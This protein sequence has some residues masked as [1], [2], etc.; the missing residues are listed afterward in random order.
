MWQ[1]ISRMFPSKE[2]VYERELR[3]AAAYRRV[4]KHGGASDTD[5]EL[6]LADLAY[7]SGFSMI[8]PATEPTAVLRQNEGKRELFARI[9]GFLNLEPANIEELENAARFEAASRERL[10]Q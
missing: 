8:T 9:R 5:R 6:V 2:S 3:L 7:Q 4:F 10:S 1:T